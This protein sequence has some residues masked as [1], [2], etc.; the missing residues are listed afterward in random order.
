MEENGYPRD[1]ITS[2]VAI[3]TLLELKQHMRW[4]ANSS[5]GR[6]AARPTVSSTLNHAERVFAA[7]ALSTGSETAFEDRCQVFKVCRL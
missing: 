4:Y 7:L 6:L 2:G 5:Q 3:P 1:S